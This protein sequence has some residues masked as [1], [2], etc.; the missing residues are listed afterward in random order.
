LAEDTIVYGMDAYQR[1]GGVPG[2]SSIGEEPK[3]YS[4]DPSGSAE[5]GERTAYRRQIEENKSHKWL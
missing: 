5:A 2:S 4:N 3:N 1:H